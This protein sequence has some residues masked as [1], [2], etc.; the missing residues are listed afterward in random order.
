LSDVSTPLGI[1]GAT[2]NIGGRVARR[3]AAAGGPMRLLVRDSSRAPALPDSEVARASYGD[4]ETARQALDGVRTLL[5]VSASETATRVREHQTFVDA[6]AAA[7]VS[8]LIYLSFFGASPTATFTLA[9]DHHLTEQHIRASGMSWTFLR[10][11]MYLDFLP[12]M[13]GEGGVIRGPAGSG[14]VAAVAQDDVAAVAVAVLTDRDAHAGTSYG[15]TGPEALTLDEVAA[16]LTRLRGRPHR[17]H[18]ETVEEAYASRASYGAP[19]WQVDA[20]VST[21]LAIARGELAAVSDDVRRLTGREP[22]SLED[23]LRRAG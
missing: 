21:Y 13:A 14:R 7:G 22:T 4:A 6:A 16:V 18:H 20:W 2:G 8:H 5:M 1:T 15:L 17:F 9:R 19:A 11:N 3:L 12:G 10:D 23:I